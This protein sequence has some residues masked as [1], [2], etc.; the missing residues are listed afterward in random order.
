MQPQYQVIDV[1]S[2]F[3]EWNHYEQEAY[4]KNKVSVR[5]LANFIRALHDMEWQENHRF[6]KD[7]LAEIA[8]KKVN[9]HE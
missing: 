3:I 2:D 7:E 1:P 9:E 6:T 4:L 5:E 8:I